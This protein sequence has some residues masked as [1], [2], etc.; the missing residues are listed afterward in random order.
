MV[1]SDLTLSQ[2]EMWNPECEIQVTLLLSTTYTVVDM[3]IT[4][5]GQGELLRHWGYGFMNLSV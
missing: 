3:A 4:T 2:C 5:I 1:L